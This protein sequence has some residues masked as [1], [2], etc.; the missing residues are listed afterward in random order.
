MQNSQFF[1]FEWL[2]NFNRNFG[3]CERPVEER[4]LVMWE[5]LKEEE[6]QKLH[7]SPSRPVDV[8]R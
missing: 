7:S 8:M 3:V 1:S 5:R 2:W 4:N 6:L